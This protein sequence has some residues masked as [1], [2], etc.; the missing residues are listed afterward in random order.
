ML[1]FIRVGAYKGGICCLGKYEKG[2]GLRQLDLKA[3]V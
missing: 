1:R 3:Q 2:S